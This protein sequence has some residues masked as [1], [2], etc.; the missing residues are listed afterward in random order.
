M[1]ASFLCLHFAAAFFCRCRGP[2]RA[3][4]ADTATPFDR[5]Q[6]QSRQGVAI[7]GRLACWRTPSCGLRSNNTLHSHSDA[8]RVELRRSS[9]TRYRVNR[10]SAARVIRSTNSASSRVTGSSGTRACRP[11]W[12]N[13]LNA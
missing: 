2:G 6:S 4:H 10:S 13:V 8:I 3:L 9:L 5:C 11:A 7:E 1:R 12:A